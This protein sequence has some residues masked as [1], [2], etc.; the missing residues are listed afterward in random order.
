[1]KKPR[2]IIGIM[3]HDTGR[4]FG[5]FGARD[6]KSPNIDRMAAEG[7]KFENHFSTGSVCVPSRA[8]ILTG[9]YFHSA[10]I[11]RYAPNQPSLPR[12]LRAAG[13]KTLRLGFAE[14]NE[15]ASPA[16][17]PLP[18]PDSDT[19]G[20]E[21][22]GYDESWTESSGAADV[23]QKLEDIVSNLGDRPTYICAS[24]HE[25]HSPYNADVTDEEIDAVV[26]P[27]DLPQ[28]PD[29]RETRRMLAQFNRLVTQADT[30]IGRILDCVKA[31]GLYGD[32]LVWFSADHGID[33][34]RAKQTCYDMGTGTPFILWGG[35]LPCH[36]VSLGG[37]SSHLD[38]GP[39]VCELA[40][41]RAPEGSLGVSQVAQLMKNAS[42]REFCVSELSRD[43]PALPVRSIRTERYRYIRNF[44]PGWP[45]PMAYS[46]AE[47]LDCDMLTELYS[48]P[49]PAEELY[50]ISAD[51]AQTNNLAEDPEYREIKLRLMGTLYAELA[52]SNDPIFYPDSEYTVEFEKHLAYWRRRED[53]TFY[54][55]NTKY[56]GG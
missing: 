34:P 16:K 54:L 30:A 39:T 48:A 47:R 46:F 27:P 13:Y 44:K 41:A 28:L 29:E 55:A 40:G 22:L 50:D 12:S 8:G 10:R 45:V 6:A 20:R 32:S 4:Q 2:L 43:C 53:G 11:C 56:S 42:P 36:G 7:V 5:C 19:S 33:F 1:M 9:Q 31:Q 52:R 23:A 18:Y 26:L 3:M 49:R 15:Y 21:L 37:L 24:F 17:A 35:A 14:E 25:A 38:I 51:P